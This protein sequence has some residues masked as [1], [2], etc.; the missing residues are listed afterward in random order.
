MARYKPLNQPKIPAAHV[1]MLLQSGSAITFWCQM[2]NSLS[3]KC[4]IHIFNLNL[5]S[6]SEC[7]D[8]MSIFQIT[9]NSLYLYVSWHACFWTE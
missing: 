7:V 1:K 4:N 5:A 2:L 3:E 9:W 8:G 6:K